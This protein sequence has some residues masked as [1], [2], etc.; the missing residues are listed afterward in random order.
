VRTHEGEGIVKIPVMKIALFLLL[1]AAPF[2]SWGKIYPQAG[3]E[4]YGGANR[5]TFLTPW[6]AARFSLSP[7]ASFILKYYHHNLQYRYQIYDA[8]S[9]AFSDKTRKASISNLTSVLYYQKD[10]TTAWG[11]VSYLMGTDSYR[12]LVFDA[13]VG[14]KLFERL[15][16]ETGVYLIRED[17]VLWYPEDAKRKINL[18]SAKGALKIKVFKGVTFNPNIYIY[19]NSEDVNAVSYS[20]GFILTP[21]DPAYITVYY[22]RYSESARYKFSG[23]YLSVGLNFYY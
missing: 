16:V 12:A 5:M 20:L 3:V 23:D 10:R 19:R 15:T 7:N 22:F 14:R 6:A 1:A 2:K 17:S 9:D 21:F 8:A 4:F 13:G 18:Y 11:A